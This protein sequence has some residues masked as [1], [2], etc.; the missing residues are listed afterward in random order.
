MFSDCPRIYKK[1]KKKKKTLII[2][3]IKQS[4]YQLP[5]VF[6]APVNVFLAILYKNSLLSKVDLG[7][8]KAALSNF[9]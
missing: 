4:H 3:I 7:D 1:K 2:I 8:F 9:D 5:T 6:K